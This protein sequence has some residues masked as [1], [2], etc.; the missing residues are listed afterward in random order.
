MTPWTCSRNIGKEVWYLTQEEVVAAGVTEQ[1]VLR[2]TLEALVAHGRPSPPGRCS[3]TPC[4]PGMLALG[5]KWIE[6]YP[7]N[8]GK[9]NLPQT[10]GLLILNDP[11][12]GCPIAIMDCVWIHRHAYAR[13]HG[14]VR[15][16][17]AS[18]GTNFRHVRVRR[19]GGGAR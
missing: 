3:S 15:R 7:D 2:L 10:A 9:F 11:L 13:G 14:P 1:D 18:R 17:P 6:C 8:P 4:R 16:R 19:A 12:S 5:M